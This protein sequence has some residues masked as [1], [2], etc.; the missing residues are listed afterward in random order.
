[1]LEGRRRESQD[2]K[3]EQR[4]RGREMQARTRAG[5]GGANPREGPRGG[6]QGEGRPRRGRGSRL[7]AA[8]VPSSVRACGRRH[9]RQHHRPPPGRPPLHPIAASAFPT[10][11]SPRGRGAAGEGREA[12][13]AA[14]RFPPAL[15]GGGAA[16]T[17]R[18]ATLGLRG[19]LAACAHV[20]AGHLHHQLPQRRLNGSELQPPPP[21]PPPPPSLRR[22]R[23]APARRPLALGRTNCSPRWGWRGDWRGSWLGSG[24]LG[25]ARAHRCPCL[26]ETAASHGEPLRKMQ[27]QWMQ[28]VKGPLL[29]LDMCQGQMA[30]GFP[31]MP[32]PVPALRTPS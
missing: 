22:S 9:L 5:T 32:A 27:S 26:Q 28:N 2:Q 1:M 25:D 11:R 18:A 13:S 29:L 20:H 10:G 14:A 24:A 7:R 17:C 3:G 23:A 12:A 4:S 6:G 30:E 19:A 15:S 31:V 16:L 8:S 21:P